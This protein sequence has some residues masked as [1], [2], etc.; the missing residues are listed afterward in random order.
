MIKNP[1]RVICGASFIFS[2]NLAF[3]AYV[4]SSFL[5]AYFTT[6]QV[7]ILYAIGS[8]TLIFGLSKISISLRRFGIYRT[9][10]GLALIN[11]LSLAVLSS[12]N[13]SQALGI[14]FITYLMTNGLI[15]FSLDELMT[16]YSESRSAGRT[17]GIFLTAVNTAWLCSPFL[18]GWII[19]QAGYGGIYWIALA[20]S[21]LL[22]IL[23][24]SR[25][26][27][28]ED[29]EYHRFRLLDIFRILRTQKAVRRIY[30]ANLLLQFFF[31]T[32][33]IYSPIYLREYIGFSWD[34]IGIIFTC[35][36]LPF[37]LFE[38][39]LGRLADRIGEKRIMGAGFLIAAVA[40]G[41][42]AFIHTPSV[43]LWAVV[44]FCTRVGAS[45]IE[46][47]SDTYFF[48]HAV[49]AK[50]PGIIGVYRNTSPLAYIIAPLLAALFISIFPYQYLFLALGIL[51]LSGIIYTA[52]IEDPVPSPEHLQ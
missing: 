26:R 24:Y 48:K 49:S 5:E 3:T 45:A 38:I 12:A 40:T 32:M 15:M 42:I 31:A 51:M 43:I 23:F 41:A 27:K 25:L 46:I 11:L 21:I 36:L 4:N 17:R 7:G 50:D 47:M 30:R 13:N 2:I 29:P 34:Q 6:R 20:C 9:V 19:G 10:I 14:F 8:I 37:V 39:P 18:A 44:L 52:T 22:I 35:M 16:K 33:V 1:L 28:Y